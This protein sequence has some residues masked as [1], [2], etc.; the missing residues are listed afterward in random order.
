MKSALENVLLPCVLS[1]NGKIL[2]SVS[3]KFGLHVLFIQTA[4]KVEG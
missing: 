2:N 4:L 3:C 1:L